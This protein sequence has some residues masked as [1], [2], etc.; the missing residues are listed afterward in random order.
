MKHVNAVRRFTVLLAFLARQLHLQDGEHGQASGFITQPEESGVEV[1]PVSQGGDSYKCGCSHDHERRDGFVKEARVHE[2]DDVA[3]GALG[4]FGL[5]VV[6]Q[7]HEN[8][9]NKRAVD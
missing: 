7:I 8:Q 9:I 2:D 6:S 5:F 1:D 3:P 4:G